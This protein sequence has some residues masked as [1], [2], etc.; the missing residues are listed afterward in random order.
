M[1]WI[2][3]L[4]EI[5]TL[6]MDNKTNELVWVREMNGRRAVKSLPRSYKL[7]KLHWEFC[8]SQKASL[9]HPRILQM[10]ELCLTTLS[11]FPRVWMEYLEYV[12]SSSTPNH[13]TFLRRLAN[14]CLESLPVTPC[15]DSVAGWGSELQ[16]QGHA[17]FHLDAM[18]PMRN[19]LASLQ[20][21][22]AGSS[23]RLTT[24]RRCW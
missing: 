24:R 5:D 7:W 6:M 1:S 22:M 18:H 13:P 16:C 10:F 3:Y 15:P 12:H 9:G 14:R 23:A 4:D 17:R 11:K 8:L 21:P 19:G 20:A 2:M